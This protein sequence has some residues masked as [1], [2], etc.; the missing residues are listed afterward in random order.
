MSK[1]QRCQGRGSIKVPARG[2]TAEAPLWTQAECPI[3][4]GLGKYET[5]PKYK[6]PLMHH[7]SATIHSSIPIE[8]VIDLLPEDT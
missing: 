8:D 6:R 2:S 1:C 7:H 3:C 5:N 4:L